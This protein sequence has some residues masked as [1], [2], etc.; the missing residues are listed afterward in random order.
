MYIDSVLV[1]FFYEINQYFSHIFYQKICT[2]SC[3]LHGFLLFFPD[4]YKHNS[5]FLYFPQIISYPR[6][7][8][9][10]IVWKIWNE[11]NNRIFRGHLHI[12]TNWLARSLNLRVLWLPLV[13]CVIINSIAKGQQFVLG[14]FSPSRLMKTISCTFWKK[15]QSCVSNSVS[16]KHAFVLNL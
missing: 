9:L 7:R 3:V 14:R 8:I 1:I 5:F 6:R 15:V 11:H 10:L 12:N 13:Y 16:K 2:S 4:S